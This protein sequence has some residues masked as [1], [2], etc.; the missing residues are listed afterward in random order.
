MQMLPRSYHIMHAQ[1]L[2]IL[3]K[4]RLEKVMRSSECL[5][6]L[7]EWSKHTG[8]YWWE[9]KNVSK[10]SDTVDKTAT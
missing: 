1:V 7:C 4:A 6:T 5:L 8:T 10:Q 3:H 9:S 2:Q